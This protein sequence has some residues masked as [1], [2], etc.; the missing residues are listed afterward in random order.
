MY[1]SSF[2][3]YLNFKK[4]IKQKDSVLR[5]H[6]NSYLFCL[7]GFNGILTLIGYFMPNPLYT[8]THIYIYIYIYIYDLSTHFLDNILKQ[9]YALFC[10]HLNGFKYCYVT[11]NLTPFI[12]L[13]TVCSIWPIDRTLSGAT[14]PGQG[15][16]GSNGNEKALYIPQISN[17]GASPSEGLMSYPGHSLGRVLPL[18]KDAVT[19]FSSPTQLGYSYLCECVCVCVYIYIYIYI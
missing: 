11:H 8:Y 5:H 16:S 4:N 3:F 6:D 12:F 2:K 19:V 10:T 17:A 14:T 9:A 18:C 1:S 13:H 7:V 15:G